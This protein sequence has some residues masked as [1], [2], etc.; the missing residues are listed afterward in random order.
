LEYDLAKPAYSQL[1][2]G[3]A[4]KRLEAAGYPNTNIREYLTG[5]EHSDE[6]SP[7]DLEAEL[8]R[9]WNAGQRRSAVMNEEFRKRYTVTAVYRVRARTLRVKSYRGFDQY[10][11]LSSGIVSN[12]IELC[13]YAFY[14]ALAEEQPLHEH[15]EIP[16]PMQTQAAYGVSQRLFETLEGNVPLVGPTLKRLLAD[17]G[18]L[19]RRRLLYHPSEPEANRLEIRDYDSI[20]DPKRAV[21]ARVM[22]EAIIWSV[23]HLSEPGEGFRTKHPGRP[24]T[25]Q[26]VINRIY[27]PVLE[28]SPRAR[29]RVPISIDD[30][31]LLIDPLTHDEAFGRLS[32]VIGGYDATDAM[33][34]FAGEDAK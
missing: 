10:A 17:L 24:P 30:I 29:W 13:K 18:A 26:L 16:G 5:Q 28:I 7:G 27:C 11:L 15:A 19:L 1:L 2:V 6:V 34:L 20:G 8:S 31:G 4:E 9:M 33:G 12:F 23:F 32:R 14:F 3:I 21:L 22:D 25:A